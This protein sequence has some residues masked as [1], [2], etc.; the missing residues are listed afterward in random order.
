[1]TK[2][3][4]DESLSQ[5]IKILSIPYFKINE[6]KNFKISS[7][8]APD[9]GFA[10]LM[11]LLGYYPID[12]LLRYEFPDDEFVYKIIKYQSVENP[13][14]SS[15]ILILKSPDDILFKFFCVNETDSLECTKELTCILRHVLEINEKNMCYQNESLV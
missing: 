9:K 10:A 12:I 13:Y 3:L 2:E 8:S 15:S 14:D 6:V 11:Q 7:E 4:I 5:N 1:M